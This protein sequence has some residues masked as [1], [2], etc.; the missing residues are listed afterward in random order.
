VAAV[1]A[2]G[3][4]DVQRFFDTLNDLGSVLAVK[5]YRLRLG[6]APRVPALP[7]LD[8]EAMLHEGI[9]PH[10]AAY[11]QDR[12]GNLHEVVYIPDA[13]RMDVEV[14]S[15]LGECSKESRDR[16]VDELKQRFPDCAVRIVF[17]SRLRG[18]YRVGNACR[19]H[20]SL[21][22]VLVGDDLDKTRASVDR[23]QLISSLMEKQSRSASW[24]ART[25]MTPLIAVAGFLSY[26][27]L[28][29]LSS[30]LD[31]AWISAIRYVVV[32][33]VGAFFLYYGVK[34]V[35]LTEMANRVWKRSTEYGLI[36]NER[37]RLAAT[38]QTHEQPGL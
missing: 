20:V 36:L 32:T 7:C 11:V 29:T 38:K 2:D 26:E 5:L 13:R 27:V 21:R 14:A 4:N 1:P 31:A 17:P 9:A 8:H 28:G 37:R 22:D 12:S 18:E 30:R 19:A 10:A 6:A 16:F 33:V 25:V 15:T 35:Q 23:L 3:A 34:A 24:G